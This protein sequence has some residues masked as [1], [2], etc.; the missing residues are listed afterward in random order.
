MSKLRLSVAL[1]G[2]AAQQI[3]MYRDTYSRMSFL[4]SS[5]DFARIQQSR[6][7]KGSLRA[8]ERASVFFYSGE[9]ILPCFLH[10][11]YVK[12]R[13]LAYGM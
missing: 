6:L 2:R 1:L 3:D 13:T 12:Y 5:S 7:K 8:W 4:G 9:S 10:P 11:M